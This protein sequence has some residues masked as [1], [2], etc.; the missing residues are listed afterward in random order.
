MNPDLEEM[1][2]S[3]LPPEQ[4]SVSAIIAQYLAEKSPI[5][6][7]LADLRFKVPKRKRYQVLYLHTIRVG[8]PPRAIGFSKLVVHNPTMPINHRRDCIASSK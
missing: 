4:I 2:R 1:M 5:F 6:K 8:I 7:E 3:T